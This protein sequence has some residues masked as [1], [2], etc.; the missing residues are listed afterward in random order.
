MTVPQKVDILSLTDAR[1][2]G[3]MAQFAVSRAHRKL[4]ESHRPRIEDKFRV[5]IQLSSYAEP[6]QAGRTVR[7]DGGLD[8]PDSVIHV[9]RLSP[10]DNVSDQVWVEI[11]GDSTGTVQAKEYI[12]SLCHG[13]DEP[14]FEEKL[15]YGFGD[16]LQAKLE[17]I[18]VETRTKIELDRDTVI[19]R[20]DEMNVAMAQSLIDQLCTDL[21]QHKESSL[22]SE[23]RQTF[24]RSPQHNSTNEGFDSVDSSCSQFTLQDDW[25]IA[26]DSFSS[27]HA[28]SNSSV[29]GRPVEEQRSPR[30][31]PRSVVASQSV[32]TTHP[33]DSKTISLTN[34][35]QKL[36]FRKEQVDL[37]LQ[38]L[39]PDADHNDV[40][41]A[42]VNQRPTKTDLEEAEDSGKEEIG[43]SRDMSDGLPSVDAPED[44]SNNLRPIIIDGSN[45]AMSFGNKDV[46][47]CKGIEIVV[48]WFCER[49]H[50]K[51]YVFVPAWRKEASKPETPITDQG[52]LNDLEKR[53]FLVWT[54]SRRING[55]RIVCYDDR[56]IVKTAVQED[57]IIVSNDNFR[58]IQN[59][60]PEY[61]KVIEERLLMYSFV[62]D[63]FMP[64]DDP[65]GR[66]GPSLDNFLRMKPTMPDHLPQACPYGKKCTYGNKCKYYHADRPNRPMKSISETLKERDKTRKEKAKLNSDRSHSPRFT[67]VSSA[68][69]PGY[70]P[71]EEIAP[72]PE[73][74][75]TPLPGP[76]TQQ[77]SPKRGSR[78]AS[79]SSALQT[80]P[81]SSGSPRHFQ[82]VESPS[83]SP[84][85]TTRD[86]T[87]GIPDL[88]P[89][90]HGAGVPHLHS[91]VPSQTLNTPPFGRANHTSP[92]PSFCQHTDRQNQRDMYTVP[93]QG[94][95]SVNPSDRGYA[96]MEESLN[97]NRM[98]MPPVMYGSGE[99]MGVTPSGMGFERRSSHNDLMTDFQRMGIHDTSG[100]ALPREP[101][102]NYGYRQSPRQYH[103]GEALPGPPQP[104]PSHHLGEISQGA[105]QPMTY[106]STEA[107]IPQHGMPPSLSSDQMLYHPSRHTP[108]PRYHPQSEPPQPRPYY[109]S[110]GPMPVT[111]TWH[112][113]GRPTP[114]N[115]SPRRNSEPAKSL[116]EQ[117]K[118]ILSNLASRF[119]HDKVN[120]VMQRHPHETNPG[121]LIMYM[122]TNM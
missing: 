76:S 101:Q 33:K 82:T 92:L 105:S 16:L 53:N 18:A 122:N 71:P 27:S 108:P 56:Y 3:R 39:G 63:Q 22:F 50:M 55:R 70:V 114:D 52:I 65:L 81:K 48:N 4:V 99:P 26:A 34:S 86:E 121:K 13:S 89:Y 19:L 96:Q 67:S 83:H 47:A 44:E 106:H 72:S 15:P 36:G 12:L 93:L 45:V 116:E 17:D 85:P 117:R 80:S 91:Q 68:P 110:P 7:G 95:P 54:P 94:Y 2:S 51:I 112:S 73:W 77:S 84:Y 38:Q 61:R 64:P 97:R 6:E 75:T 120:A 11:E 42:L 20:G 62:N 78:I 32:E 14:R 41:G 79:E 49:G 10:T 74:H 28:I 35:M 107:F 111:S 60:K 98:S 37:V 8:Q 100:V 59:E 118:Y 115:V 21:K 24:V 46:F 87:F 69:I 57:G 23:E 119:G 40:L 9:D 31:I 109:P 30:L 104:L 88:Q 1:T 90:Q 58:D 29:M 102:P 66:H 25:T 113:S 103:N 43:G 5:A